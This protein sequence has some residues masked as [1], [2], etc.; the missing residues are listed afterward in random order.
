MVGRAVPWQPWLLGTDIIAGTFLDAL[1][2]LGSSLREFGRVL[3][4]S[5]AF[6]LAH[7]PGSCS[8]LLCEFVEGRCRCS[9]FL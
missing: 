8:D 6:S 2:S 3:Q 5:A 9:L 1:V 7:L 4:G